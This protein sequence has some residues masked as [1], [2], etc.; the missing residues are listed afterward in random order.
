[1]LFAYLPALPCYWDP[2]TD[3]IPLY[4]GTGIRYVAVAGAEDVEKKKEKE[5]PRKQRLGGRP[6]LWSWRC[7]DVSSD[8]VQF[9]VQELQV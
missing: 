6:S 3:P 7:R 2:I 5:E 9:P 8:E 4:W 1:M